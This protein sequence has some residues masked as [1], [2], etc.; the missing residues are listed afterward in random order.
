M[1]VFIGGKIF[2]NQLVGKLDPTISLGVA[3]ALIAGGVVYSLWKT[4]DGAGDAKAWSDKAERNEARQGREERSSGIR[5]RAQP[6]PPVPWLG[7]QPCV[8]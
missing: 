7:G 3:F 1:L 5:K 6:L 2:W 4:K 8:E